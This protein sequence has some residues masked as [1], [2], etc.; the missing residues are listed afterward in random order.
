MMT[1]TAGPS[2]RTRLER[3][4]TEP[5]ILVLG[6]GIAGLGAADEAMR[7]GIPAL[8]VE[9][10]GEIGARS[11]KEIGIQTLRGG[12]NPGEHTVMFVGNGERIELIHRSA[13]REHFAS[14]AV[15]AAAWIASQGPGLYDMEQVLGLPG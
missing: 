8:V 13:T 11:E 10:A 6:G 12:D 2:A 9:R 7:A 3:M 5:P 15:R 4:H 1:T 14:G